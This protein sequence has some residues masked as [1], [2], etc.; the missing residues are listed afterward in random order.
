LGQSEELDLL[1]LGVQFLG[2]FLETDE[3]C[4][5]SALFLKDALLLLLEVCDGLLLLLAQFVEGQAL[6]AEPVAL[7]LELDRA[8]VLLGRVALGVRLL[9]EVFHVG[10]DSVHLLLKS[11]EEVV[12]MTFDDALDVEA[13]VLGWLTAPT[14]I[15]LWICELISKICSVILGLMNASAL[16]APNFSLGDSGTIWVVNTFC[17]RK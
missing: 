5:G 1:I 16:N 4:V 11:S 10:L 2:C 3:L 14:L 7:L 9:F 6:A 12:L 15:C 17:W 8:L 13:G